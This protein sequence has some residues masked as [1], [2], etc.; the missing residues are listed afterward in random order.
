MVKCAHAQE[1]VRVGQGRENPCVVLNMKRSRVSGRGSSDYGS[2]S[3]SHSRKKARLRPEDNPEEED[4]GT[5]EMDTSQSLDLVVSPIESQEEGTAQFKSE[6][7]VVSDNSMGKETP[8]VWV[9]VS[10]VVVQSLVEPD[11]LPTG[12]GS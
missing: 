12:E 3:S 10:G 11:P 6:K 8:G 2:P 7:V 9:R 4:G 5:S 1:H